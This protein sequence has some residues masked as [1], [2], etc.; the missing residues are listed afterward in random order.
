MVLTPAGSLLFLIKRSFSHPS[1]TIID[2]CE[3]P[4]RCLVSFLKAVESGYKA[5]PYHNALHGADVFQGVHS[6]LLSTGTAGKLSSTVLLAT[7]TAALAH[8]IGHFGKNNTFL[9]NAKHRLA[10]IYNDQHILENMHCS[11]VGRSFSLAYAQR[12]S[13]VPSAPPCIL[14]C[15]ATDA[16]FCSAVVFALLCCVLLCPCIGLVLSGAPF[17]S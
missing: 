6:L 2:D 3:V 13:L 12:G 7:L 5:N 14:F 10:L 17:R 15:P 8:D 9:V 16:Y 11:K 1:Y 4:V